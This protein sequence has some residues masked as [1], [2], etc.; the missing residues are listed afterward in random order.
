MNSLSRDSAICRKCEHYLKCNSKM[1]E[2][3]AFIIS[4]DTVAQSLSQTV[5]MP[6]M[7]E[8]TVKHDYRNIKISENT[9]V[10]IDIEEMKK[11]LEENFYKQLDLGIIM[12]G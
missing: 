7:Q 3:C 8:M 10:T 9:T 6:I 12:K 4:E 11:K 2:A 1:M 5:S